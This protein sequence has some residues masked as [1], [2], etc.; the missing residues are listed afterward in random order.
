VGEEVVKGTVKWFDETKGFG[1]IQPDGATKDVFVH[2]TSVE[3]GKMLN[4]GDRVEFEIGDGKKGK[5]ALKVK[6]L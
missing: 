6:K 3:R 2:K 1:F 5:Q 4:E